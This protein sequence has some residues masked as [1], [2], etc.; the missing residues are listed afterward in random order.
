MKDRA[1]VVAAA[2]AGLDLC[3]SMIVDKVVVKQF[4]VIV[5]GYWREVLPPRLG[6]PATPPYPPQWCGAFALSCLRRGGLGLD[7]FWRFETAT[8]KRS[9]FLYAL[10]Q[11]H[12]V[13]PEPGDMCYLAAPYQHHAV[14]CHVCEVDGVPNVIT[15]NGNQGAAEPIK[16][17]QH[18][19]T[20]W[21]A[22][23]SIAG[24]LPSENVA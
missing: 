14:V 7:L 20:H 2:R 6:K 8:D 24:L 3:A 1:S 18:P 15:I 10:H 9:G 23:Y 5:Q 11:L 12:G 17:A 13:A 21:T 22:F 16:L 4:P 19:L